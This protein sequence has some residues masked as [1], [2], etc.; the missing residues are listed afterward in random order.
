MGRRHAVAG[1]P[2]GGAGI[3]APR[4]SRA[5]L[6]A[7]IGGTLAL[8]GVLAFPVLGGGRFAP[9][10]WTLAAV[11][12]LVF[13]IALVPRWPT[14]IP[15]AVLLAGAAYLVG[16]NGGSVVDGWSSVAGAL[17]LLAAELATW[18][19]DADPRIAAETS[20]TV[21]RVVSL[22]A[23]VAVAL[24]VNFLLLATAAIS[25]SAGLL[26][27]AI[28]VAATVASVAYVLRLLRA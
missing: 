2:R 24:F 26:V 11:A 3:P 19:I 10:A 9:L 5:R 13:A 28:G 15:W 6:I 4:T 21:R 14:A 27:A 17:L 25:S 20:L 23:L 22:A 8:C 1:R 12:L 16:R 18:S 7:G